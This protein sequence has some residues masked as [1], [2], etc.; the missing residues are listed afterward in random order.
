MLSLFQLN[1]TAQTGSMQCYASAFDEQLKMLSGKARMDYKRS[2]FLTENAF[3]NGKLDYGIFC[4]EISNTGQQLK[5]LIKQ[6]GLEKYKTSGNWAVFTYMTDS[7]PVNGFKPC[8]YDFED[9][10]GEKDWTKMFVTKLMKT[11]KGNCHSLPIYYKILCEEIGA[12]AFLA[13]APNHLYIKHTDEKGQWTNVELTNGGFPR[14]QW[15]I[16]EMAITVEA[17]RNGVY[18][19]ALTEKESIALCMFDL[20]SAYQFQHGYDEFA[21]KMINTALKYFPNCIPLLLTKANCYSAIGNKNN[22]SLYKETLS[23]VDSLGYKE[24][25]A[26]QYAEWVKSVE[27]EKQKRNVN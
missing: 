4:K 16:K 1:V 18:M 9:F 25:E 11:S 24:M 5:A 23:K 21:L 3:H 17:I 10:M 8:I 19:Q 15:M 22:Y 20:I 27:A 14:D 26:E 12:K 7:I 13:L 6:K 2:V